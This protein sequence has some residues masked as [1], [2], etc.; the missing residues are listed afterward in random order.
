MP[1]A[2]WNEALN[3]LLMIHNRSLVSYVKDARPWNGYGEVDDATELL[4]AIVTEQRRVVDEI[5][6]LLVERN[7]ATSN[8][9]YPLSYTALNDLSFA[10]LLRKLITEQRKT[11]ST[12]ESIVEQLDEDPQGLV[13]AQRALGAAKA[14]L[15]MLETTRKP[16]EATVV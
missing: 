8:G 2:R 14:H 11:I 7:Y 1:Q 9:E 15:E 13:L 12:I 4:D 5:G 6:E 10:Y 3:R 16:P